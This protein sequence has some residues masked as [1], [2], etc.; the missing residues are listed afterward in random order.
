M[1]RANIAKDREERATRLAKEI[2][3]DDTYKANIALEVG[4]GE[5]D[6]E[7]AFSAVFDSGET[8]RGNKYVPPHLRKN[9]H[10]GRA[11]RQFLQQQS[12]AS[13]MNGQLPSSSKAGTPPLPG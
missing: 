6:E 5:D 3:C 10:D 12:S 1:N 13:A 11:S 7:K 8:P 4:G 2:E 9:P